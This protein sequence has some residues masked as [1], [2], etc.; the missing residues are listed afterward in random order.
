LGFKLTFD[1]HDDS[2][3]VWPLTGWLG[4]LRYGLHNINIMYI[5][6]VLSAFCRQ[7]RDRQSWI[8][9]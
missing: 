4:F 7:I 1:R 5:H 2:L 8:A 3:N 6:I 9:L